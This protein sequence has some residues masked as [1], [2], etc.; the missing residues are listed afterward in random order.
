MAVDRAEEMLMKPNPPTQVLVH[1]LKLATVRERSE[2]EKME[3]EKELLRSRTE[4]LRAGTQQDERYERIT[5]I[6][7]GYQ[8]LEVEDYDP[9]D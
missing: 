5:R 2:M 8:G 9:D 6:F 3:L 7:R 1:Y 4:S